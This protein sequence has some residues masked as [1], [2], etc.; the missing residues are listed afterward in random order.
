MAPVKK[1]QVRPKY[2]PW[3]TNTTKDLMN[4]R[5]LAQKRAAKSGDSDDWKEFKRLRN[6][7]NGL[8]KHEKRSW[9]SRRLDSCSSTSDIWKTVK[10]WLGWR[11]GGPPTQLVINGELKN[12]PKELADCMNEYFVNKVK[13]L[14]RKIPPCRKNPLDRAE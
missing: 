2:A 3:L 7:I 9:E 11:T 10:N 12:K 6:R 5:D 14:R 4:E 1:Y 13:D 8:L